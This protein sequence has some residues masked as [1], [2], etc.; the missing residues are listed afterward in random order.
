[1]LNDRLVHHLTPRSWGNPGPAGGSPWCGRYAGIPLLGTTPSETSICCHHVSMASRRGDVRRSASWPTSGDR[2]LRL[3]LV[4]SSYPLGNELSFPDRIR[5]AA[6]AGFDGI[7]LRAENYWDA[8]RSGLD[9]AAMAGARRRGWRACPGGRV[10]HLVG[11]PRA[12]LA[13]SRFDIVRETRT[14]QQSP[15]PNHVAGTASLRN[16]GEC[17]VAAGVHGAGYCVVSV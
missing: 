6:A 14:R 12:A 4:V 8:E 16:W 11:H 5:A 3:P 10:H 17:V 2:D 1:M 15:D 13:P 7:G 9:G